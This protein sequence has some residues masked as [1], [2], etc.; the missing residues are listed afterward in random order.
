MSSTCSGDKVGDKC[1]YT[2]QKGYNL[3]GPNERECKSDGQW[4]HSSPHCEGKAMI[5][6]LVK[7]RI[8]KVFV[9]LLKNN[10]HSVIISKN[11]ADLRDL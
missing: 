4:S 3:V 2:C 5:S 7:R 10:D 8:K 6:T 9:V 1:S 11:T